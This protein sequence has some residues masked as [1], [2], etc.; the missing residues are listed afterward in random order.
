[1]GQEVDILVFT[2]GIGQ[3]GTGMHERICNRPENIGI[4]MDYRKNLENG[5]RQGL[6]SRDYSPPDIVVIPT[7]EELQIAVDTHRLV[8]TAG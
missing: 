6:M 5:P 8:K 4:V 7:N 3:Y 1:M 2:E